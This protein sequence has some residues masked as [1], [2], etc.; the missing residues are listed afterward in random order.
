MLCPKSIRRSWVG[1]LKQFNRRAAFDNERDAHTLRWTARCDQ[2][3][4]AHQLRCKVTHLKSY[5]GTFRTNS[6]IGASGSN[7][8][9]RFDNSSEAYGN[10]LRRLGYD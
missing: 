1:E 3:F 10:V 7:C 8:V 5:T 6:G 2:D 9:D 4:P